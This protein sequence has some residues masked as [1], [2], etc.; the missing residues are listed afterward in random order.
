MECDGMGEIGL[1]RNTKTAELVKMN[2]A[3]R[4]C[5]LTLDMIN[6]YFYL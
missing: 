6:Y 4:G 5:D 2:F 1:V 3:G